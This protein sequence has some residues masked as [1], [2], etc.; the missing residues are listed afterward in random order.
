MIIS[1]IEPVAS[2]PRRGRPRRPKVSEDTRLAARALFCEL[3]KLF[4]DDDLYQFEER[5]RPVVEALWAVTTWHFAYSERGPGWL[6]S[7]RQ[8]TEADKRRLAD[9]QRLAEAERRALRRMMI[10]GAK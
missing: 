4:P 7:Q 1:G 6:D 5:M 3:A 2:S 10:G 8:A 9:N